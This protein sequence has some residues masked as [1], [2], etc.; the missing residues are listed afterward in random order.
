MCIETSSEYLLCGH[1]VVHVE[2]CDEGKPIDHSWNRVPHIF[3]RH[4]STKSHKFQIVCD[5]EECQALWAAAAKQANAG[6]R[7]LEELQK[8]QLQAP[9]QTAI[10]TQR[11]AEKDRLY[12]VELIKLLKTDPKRYA[13]SV[14]QMF[15]QFPQRFENIKG[16][17]RYFEQQFRLHGTPPGWTGVD[18]ARLSWL[19]SETLEKFSVQNTTAH[20]QQQQHHQ[21]SHAAEY[22]AARH[23]ANNGPSTIAPDRIKQQFR[24]VPSTE[25]ESKIIASDPVLGVIYPTQDFWQRHPKALAG[26]ADR[27]A[28]VE[29]MRVRLMNTM[30]FTLDEEHRMTSRHGLL[31]SE[32]TSASALRHS[33]FGHHHDTPFGE[34]VVDDID[35][36]S[37]GM[38]DVMVEIDVSP[39]Y[40]HQHQFGSATPQT[41]TSMP[42]HLRADGRMDYHAMQALGSQQ[43][44]PLATMALKQ[45]QDQYIAQAKQLSEAMM[46]RRTMP[47]YGGQQL[48]HS[49]VETSGLQPPFPSMLSLTNSRQAMW[50]RPL[51]GAPQGSPDKSPVFSAYESQQR[52]N[53]GNVFVDHGN[54]NLM[55]A[56]DCARGGQLSFGTSGGL[57]RRNVPPPDKNQGAS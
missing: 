15:A 33:T 31:P 56:I 14:R 26:I 41:L 42:S 54:N 20:Q 13:H 38:Q 22:T 36:T 10:Q 39:Q 27:L 29:R 40:Q 16:H 37:D 3:C 25:S 50:H 4:L 46:Q 45:K 43:A 18:V 34:A 24:L 51:L 2:H 44:L 28:V 21:Q 53:D 8:Q 11:N 35:L 48:I 30:S 55:G 49:Q 57:I 32:G 23:G 9:D 17:M 5:K 7:R 52:G 12:A 6:K 1:V 19:H 47:P